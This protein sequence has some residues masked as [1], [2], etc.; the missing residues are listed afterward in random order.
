MLLRCSGVGR[1]AVVVQSTNV[2]DAYAI[3]VVAVSV[4]TLQFQWPARLHSAVE[5]YHIVIAYHG[6]PLLTMPTVYIRRTKVL[7]LLSGRTV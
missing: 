2:A 4:C 7:T 3:S 1:T 6:V 5:Q